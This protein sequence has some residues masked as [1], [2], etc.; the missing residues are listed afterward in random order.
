[1]K[2]IRDFKG[3]LVYIFG[4]SSGIGL[5]IAKGFS[6][7]GARVVLLSRSTAKLQS[8]VVEVKTAGKSGTQTAEYLEVDVTDYQNVS[9][10]MSEGCKRFGVPDILINCAGRAAP[11]YFEKIPAEQFD[12]TMKINMHGTWNTCK[13][14]VPY[15]K[16]KG[17][18]IV[19]TSSMAGFLGVFGYTDY[20][21]SKFAVMGFSEAL[22][23]E[24]DQYS[25][26]LSVLCPPDTD[27][28][29]FEAEN[30]TKPAE[31][32]LISEGVRL[33][34]PGDVA[35]IFLKELK[36]GRFVIVPGTSGKMT[37]LLKRL[38]P[39]AVYNIMKKKL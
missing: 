9:S 5:N 6:A 34:Q 24:L 23:S 20:A 22:R 7:E 29:G 28:P 18:W 30:K 2:G 36:K 3:R 25:I 27:T 8:A 11:Q 31:T 39:S 17:G 33:M 4:G 38:M 14:A 19:N 1:M 26:G 13:A 12:E 15:M 32:K 35:E 16:E 21:A 10:V 37:Y